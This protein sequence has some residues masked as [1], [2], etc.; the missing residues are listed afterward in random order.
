[1]TKWV[2]VGKITDDFETFKRDLLTKYPV[3][4]VYYMVKGRVFRCSV[5]SE[6]L[7]H[8]LI[9]KNKRFMK[10]INALDWNWQPSCG[11]CNRTAHHTDN[12][13]N[14]RWWLQHQIDMYGWDRIVADM[15]EAPQ[16]MKDF[17]SDWNEVWGWLIELKG[18]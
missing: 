1:M 12:R 14:R 15:Q 5:P 10:Y 16:K 11:I 13:E 8:C 7:D 6:D 18:E 2:N 3:C 4:Q 17:N 9:R